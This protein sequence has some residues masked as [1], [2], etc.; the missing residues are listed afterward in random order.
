MSSR[1]E[2]ALRAGR[3][4]KWI[5]GAS[6]QDLAAIEDL[7]GLYT[8]AG[9]HCLDVAADPAVVAAA[10]RGIAWAC[11]RG[12]E[13]PW[14]MVSL[15]DGGDP[16]F[17]KAWFDPSRCP[18]D[19]PRP[20]ARVCPALAIDA[21]GVVA[22][23]C[24]G[25]GRCR[26]A[27]PLGLIEE[28]Q[29]L[30]EP[31][32]VPAL[33]AALR[34]DAVELHTRLGRSAAFAERLEQ[35]LRSGV[36]L[37]R[38]A[39]SCG[40]EPA[41]GSGDP[42]DRAETVRPEALAAEL[43]DR[44]RLLRAAGFRPLWQLDGRPMSGDVGGGTAHAAVRLLR[45][46]AAQAPP[47][48]LQLAGGTNARTLALVERAAVPGVAG[49]AFGGVARSLLQP[50]LVQAQAGGGRLLDEPE[51]RERALGIARALVDPWLHRRMGEP[52]AFAP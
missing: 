26:P 18:A 23:R 37:K 38:L 46:V 50:L 14:L 52:V 25:C 34:P 22:P 17:R 40:L 31:E 8:W 13:P 20:C 19:C 42:S 1:P 48:P 9:V 5:G 45:R 35:L 4:V 32:A 27:C 47:G 21:A 39:V 28:R 11:E 16:H 51:L 30:L 29:Q 12:A 15:S 41:A 44:F 24:Y 43:W 36:S 6:N 33:L 2:Q 49:V 10:R 3:W 7:A